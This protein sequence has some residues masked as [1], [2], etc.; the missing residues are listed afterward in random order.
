MN[1]QEE[2]FFCVDSS[3]FFSINKRNQSKATLQNTEL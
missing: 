1:T 2:T 3:V